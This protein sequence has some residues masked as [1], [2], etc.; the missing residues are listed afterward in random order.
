MIGSLGIHSGSNKIEELLSR[1]V[2]EIIDRSNLKNKLASGKQLRIKLGID[3]TSPNI[4]LGRS[5]PL[6]K[7]RDFQELGHK[8]I[9]IIGDF[10]GLIGDISDKESERPMLAEE[11]VKENL[12]TYLEQ[13]GKI[14]DVHQAEIRHNSGW[15]GKLGYLDIG[16]QADIFSL[17]VFISRENISRRLED[18]RRV[19]L[20]ELLYPLMQGYDSVEVRADVEIGGTDQRFNLLAG[21][22]VQRLYG[23]EP[24]DILTNPLIE[25]LDG[26]KMSSS[27][28]NTVNVFDSPNDMFWKIMSLQD[29]LIVKYFILLTRVEMKTI[30]GY[31]ESLRTGAN[32]RD[33][34]MKLAFEVVRMYH[35][36]KEARVAEDYFV[37]TFSKKETPTDRQ[38]FKPNKYDIVSVLIETKIMPSKSEARRII[39]QGGVK[40]DSLVIKDIHYVV[41]PGSVL[42]KGKIKF[43]EVL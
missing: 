43:L 13:V 20:R 35:S 1:G 37:S 12:K 34:K 36:E 3:P 7:L 10:T 19:S 42:Q 15:L 33:F 18:G 32:P 31:E 17:N 25:G 22:D 6:L 21:R 38:K 41:R 29:G 27:F 4:H 16:R 40:I 24:Q 9:L 11:A 14:I 2:E 23:Q 8:V 28:G 39:K 30:N 26:R 5:I